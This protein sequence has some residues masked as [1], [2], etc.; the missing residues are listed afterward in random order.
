[1]V[2]TQDAR[3]SK[4]NSLVEGLQAMGVPPAGGPI[5]DLALTH[6][7][8][9]FEQAEPVPH[10]ERLEFLGDAVL[11]LIVTT[12]IYRTYPSLS[13]G[14]MTRLRRLLVST[15]ALADLAGALGVGD[16]IR[17]GKGEETSG[18]R[19]KPSL[20][21]DTFEAIVG[22]VY[23]DRGLDAVIQSLEPIFARRM[24]DAMA[25]GKLKESKAVLQEL[26]VKD[27]GSLPNYKVASTGPEHDK[28]FI[29]HVYIEGELFGVGNG[30]TKKEAEEN[31][32]REAMDRIEP[33]G[34][35][36]TSGARA[37]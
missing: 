19:A 16:H 32:A 30:R 9:A 13:E 5:Y 33:R 3:P 20:L 21:A 29:A 25:S 27:G 10:N 15:V 35:R 31:A 7:S 8:F 11:G 4:P 18:G 14:E 6:R 22:A 17:L 26:L 34:G 24:H 37:S 2:T 12:L 28:R 36:G 23:V 1:V